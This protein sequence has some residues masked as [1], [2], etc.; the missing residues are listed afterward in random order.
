[1]AHGFPQ[2]HLERRRVATALFVAQHGQRQ[3]AG[4]R[5]ED[6]RRRVRRAV[7]D[8]EY[9]VIALEGRHHLANL[10]EQYADGPCFVVG[11]D[12]DVNHVR[13]TRLHRYTIGRRPARPWRGA[14]TGAEAGMPPGGRTRFPRAGGE[15]RVGGARGVSP[16]SYDPAT[17]WRGSRDRVGGLPT[18]DAGPQRPGAPSRRASAPP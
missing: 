5:L 8:H 12:T 17:A 11:R 9:L 6:L 7:I 1:P 3:H 15:E 16:P 10:P 2:E 4:V 13:R 14:R 18:P